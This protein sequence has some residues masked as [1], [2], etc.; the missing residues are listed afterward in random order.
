MAMAT[1]VV[2]EVAEVVEAAVGQENVATNQVQGL[3][4]APRPPKVPGL[5]KHKS[6]LLVVLPSVGEL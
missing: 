3:L 1:A 4:V 5:G 6:E 2:L